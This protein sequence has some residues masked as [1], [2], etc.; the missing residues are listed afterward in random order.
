[1]EILLSLIDYQLPFRDLGVA[2]L[3]LVQAG[4]ELVIIAVRRQRHQLLYHLVLQIV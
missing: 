2:K 3:Y 4:E 1:M